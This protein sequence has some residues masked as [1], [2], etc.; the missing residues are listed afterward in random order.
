M[1]IIG[2]DMYLSARKY[3]SGANYTRDAEDN[4]VKHYNPDYELL[5]GVVGLTAGDAREDVPSAQ[6]EVTVGYWRKV[7]A[8][9][10]WFVDNCANGEDD[11]RPASVSRDQLVELRDLCR[12]VSLDHDK[13][14]DLLPSAS[15][16]FFGSTEYDEWYFQGIEETIEM[17]DRILANPRFEFDSWDFQYQASW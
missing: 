8:V 15:G 17:L 14:E 13:A 12:E 2:L 9:H 10:I 4:L 3:L 11:C 6:V 7:N 5:L 16:F 1:V